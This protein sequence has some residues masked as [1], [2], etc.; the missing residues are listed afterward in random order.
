MLHLSQIKPPKERNSLGQDSLNNF[1]NTQP[2]SDLPQAP[3]HPI[4]AVRLWTGS[5]GPRLKFTLMMHN[6]SKWTSESLKN[7]RCVIQGPHRGHAAGSAGSL[8]LITHSVA[9]LH[10]TQEVHLS[11]LPAPAMPGAGRLPGL[12]CI[13]EVTLP[14]V[15]P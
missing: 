6:C 9:Q 3:K 5:D 4:R 15:Q 8:L 13:R 7:R 10:E 2:D 12:C 14:V 11:S 1:L